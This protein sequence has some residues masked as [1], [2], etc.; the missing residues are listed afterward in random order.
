MSLPLLPF[1]LIDYGKLDVLAPGAARARVPRRARDP[2]EATGRGGGRPHPAAHDLATDCGDAAAQCAGGARVPRQERRHHDRL[3]GGR[4]PNCGRYCALRAEPYDAV[5]GLTRPAVRTRCP[6]PRSPPQKLIETADWDPALALWRA[7]F[8]H[9]RATPT[10]RGSCVRDGRHAYRSVDVSGCIGE[11]VLERFDWPVSLTE[12]DMEVVCILFHSFLIAGISLADPARIKFKSRLAN[13]DRSALA[14]DVN[15]V[16]T[17]RPSTTYLMFV[18][19][20]YELGE[21]FLDSMCG[22]GTI[23]VGCAAFS[24]NRVFALGGELD[25]LPVGKAGQNARARPRHVGVLQ[26]DS[27]RLPLRSGVVDKVLIDMPFGMRCGNHRLNNRVRSANVL[28]CGRSATGV[29]LAGRW[30]SAW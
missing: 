10:F 1:M 19:A 14:V 17:L 18:L 30:R 23:P 3:D 24:E 21:L 25:A 28:H 15:Y 29:W 22:V 12:F 6:R 20:E 8:P 5:L 13:E 7:H 26:W 27:T 4:K 11:G 16:S 9:A 2:R